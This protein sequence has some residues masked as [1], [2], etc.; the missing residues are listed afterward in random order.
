MGCKASKLTNW[1]VCSSRRE[2]RSQRIFPASVCRRKQRWPIAN[3][4]IHL[5]HQLKTYTDD[6]ARPYG[7]DQPW[8]PSILTI[9]F[10]RFRLA[11]IYFYGLVRVV[12]SS[13]SMTAR[14]QGQ[15]VV[16]P[17]TRP[18]NW[19]ER[20]RVY[21]PGLKTLTSQILQC[22]GEIGEEGSASYWEPHAVQIGRESVSI[23][24][25]KQYRK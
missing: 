19:F 8:A 20:Y 2:M 10:Y 17:T 21:T 14:M 3:F 6:I 11:A 12:H 13:L 7:H 5:H 9:P 22:C 16:D 25:T 24:I 18:V 4:A 1:R 15:I 23:L